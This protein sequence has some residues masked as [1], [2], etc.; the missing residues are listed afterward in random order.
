[1]RG[2]GV[3]QNFLRKAMKGAYADK[4]KHTPTTTSEKMKDQR[5]DLAAQVYSSPR[6]ASFWLIEIDSATFKALSAQANVALS[7]LQGSRY[8][9]TTPGP[10]PKRQQS[11]EIHTELLECCQGW[12]RVNDAELGNLQGQLQ[13]KLSM[14]DAQE[15]MASSSRTSK[16]KAAPRPSTAPEAKAAKKP[17][18]QEG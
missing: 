18:K 16:A 11:R 17:R 8:E 10:M 15:T 3:I 2:C 1:M 13:P 12:L 14:Q 6:W 7:S 9:L 5:Q 4:K